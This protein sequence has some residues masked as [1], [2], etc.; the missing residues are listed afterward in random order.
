M[1]HVSA[2]LLAAGRGMRMGFGE[3]KTF[4]CLAGQPVLAYSLALFERSPEIA[5]V[6]LVVGEGEFA[7][8]QDIC[9]PYAKVKQIVIGGPSRQLS[10]AN[11]LPHVAPEAAYVLVHDAARPFV[12]RAHLEALFATEL[13]EGGATLAAPARYTIK[14]SD[15]AG[16]VRRTLPRQNLY[17]VQTPQLF[18]RQALLDAYARLQPED[19]LDATD[20][21]SLVEAAGGSIRL[22][23]SDYGNFKLT[24]AEDWQLAQVRLG[25]AQRFGNGFD[26]HRLVPGR[27]LIL[28]GVEIPF[29]KG[30]LGHSD[31]DVL[32]HAVTDALLGAANL[33]DLGHHFPDSD[34]RWKDVS[35][36]FLLEQAVILAGQVGYRPCQV[37]CTIMAERPKLAP[38][39]P[40]M[41]E[42]IAQALGLSPE[43]IS[44][45]AT[46]CEGLGLCGREEGMGAWAIVTLMP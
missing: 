5:E 31:A 36:R 17:E 7:C 8:A 29:E 24:T 6:L 37:D 28:G 21:A 32:L 22:I 9:A 18:T 16:L 3:N 39:I 46:T 45:K 27:K 14:E 12:Q 1:E 26:M 19:L 4:A 30:L 43:K 35:S 25:M 40:A 10:V 13:E 15:G 11:A 41:R 44:V 33:G 23:E 34:V 2:I 20:D 42:N 38:F